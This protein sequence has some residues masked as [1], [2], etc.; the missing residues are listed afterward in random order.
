MV[1]KAPSLLAS[2]DLSQDEIPNNIINDDH[3]IPQDKVGREILS[4]SKPLLLPQDKNSS[5]GSSNFAS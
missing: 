5:H 1:P 4:P 3:Y 2:S